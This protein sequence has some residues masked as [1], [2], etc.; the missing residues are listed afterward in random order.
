ME[1]KELAERYGISIESLRNEQLKLAKSLD[2]KGNINISN[3]ERIGAIETVIVKNKIIAV[4]IICDKDFNIIEQQYFFDSLK[5][6]YIHGLRAYRELPSMIGAF[7]KLSE[8]P[9]VVLIHGPG[10]MQKDL[11]IA[12]HFSLLTKIT[13]IGVNEDVLE[14]NKLKGEDIFIN[15]K[16]VGKVLISKE[17]SKPIYLSP[18]NSIS[19]K[20]AY[21]V[22]KILVKEPHK[23]PEPLHLAHKYAKSVREELKI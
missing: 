6:P 14:E 20:E 15:E 18:G 4:T 21:D 5:F 11:G 1:E 2:L 22:C 16:K 3:I 13:S 10:I 23:L 19:I 8:R 12:S 9:D 17:N 7:D